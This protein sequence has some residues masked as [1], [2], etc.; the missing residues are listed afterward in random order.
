[1]KSEDKF[2]RQ[3]Y[4]K[5]FLVLKK[6]GELLA[7]L[8]WKES[9]RKPNLFYRVFHEIT[10]FA[11]MRGTKII[12]IWEDPSPLMYVSAKNH[13][14]WE[15]RRA[16]RNAV[17]ELDSSGIPHRFSFYDEAE[18][19]GLFFGD[20][21]VLPDGKCKLC[22]KEFS[23]DSLFCSEKCEDTN[24]QLEKLRMEVRARANNVECAV[25]GKTVKEWGKDYIMHHVDYDEEKTIPVCRSCHPFVHSRHEDY[26]DLA[27]RKP[28]PQ[29][30][31]QAKRGKKRLEEEK[32]SIDDW[33]AKYRGQV[34][35]DTP[36]ELFKKRKAK[37]DHAKH[38]RY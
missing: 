33:Q 8:G 35:T 21:D 36:S 31:T 13:Q 9:L 10:V 25:C 11:D 30:S 3:I 18:L 28:K 19:E 6:Y 12:P 5:T 38:S 34:V 7:G 14:D 20:P 15:R 32:L 26:P 37:R 1:M 27:P 4:P 16:M 23:H 2:G 22:G 29:S 17:E 24:S